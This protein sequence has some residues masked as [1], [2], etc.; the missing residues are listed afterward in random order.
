MKSPKIPFAER[1]LYGRISLHT[2]VGKGVRRRGATA[3]IN[4][5]LKLQG[6]YYSTTSDALNT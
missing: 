6:H 5:Q 1:G 3:R 4:L 2:G